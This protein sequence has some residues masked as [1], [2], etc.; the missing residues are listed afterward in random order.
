VSEGIVV[1]G[2]SALARGRRIAAISIGANLALSAAAIVVGRLA[3][4]TS[5]V[6]AGVEFAGDVLAAAFVYAG[7]RIAARPADSGHPYGHG[8]AEILTG[9]VL[10]VV[11]VLAGVSIA[12]Q[13]LR[14]YAAVHPPPSIEA[15]WPLIAAVAV[16]GALVNV[17]YR[18]GRRI[19]SAALTADAW[20]DAV[21][22]VSACAALTALGLTLYDPSRFLA[23]DHFGGFAVGVIVI[24]TGVRV[25]R[26]T[27]LELMDTMPD[28][29][30]M[31]TIRASAQRVGEVRGVEKCFARKTGLRYHVDLHLE[32]D[33]Q[34]SVADGHAIAE[35]V[36]QRI[37]R[38]VPEVADVLVHVEPA[39]A[40]APPG[41][42][43]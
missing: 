14:A 6:A 32:V 20:N 41:S 17:K 34:T 23:A 12:T 40:P 3:G 31:D 19:R 1:E 9:L 30:L 43:R 16:K 21:D 27:S 37:R 25:T 42:E 33:P 28:A 8:R 11:L 24:A 5:A 39:P 15:V 7:F 4:S 38:D 18:V 35:R 26:D 2:S 22:I 36:R 13:S 29:Q 10:G